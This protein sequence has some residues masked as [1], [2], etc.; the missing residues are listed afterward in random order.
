MKAITANLLAS[1]AVVYLDGD[2]NWVSRLA[3]AHRFAAE[4]A[5]AALQLA[6]LRKREIAG[7]Y[8]VDVND[9]GAEGRERLRETIRNLGPT[10]RTDL[11][12]QAG[13]IDG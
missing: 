8:L 6:L 13:A 4:E 12:K 11:G 2:G 10:V 5:D 9:E 7:A 1:G 3:E